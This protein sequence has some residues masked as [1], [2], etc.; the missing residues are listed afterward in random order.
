MNS[1]MSKPEKFGHLYLVYHFTVRLMF[2]DFLS[3]IV[4]EFPIY[5]GFNL[6]VLENQA[7]GSFLTTPSKIECM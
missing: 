4:I 2:L 1:D 3:S 5:H 6:N 7:S